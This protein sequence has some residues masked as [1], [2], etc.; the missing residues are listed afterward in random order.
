MVGCT[1]QYQICNPNLESNVCTPSSGQAAL[2]GLIESLYLNEAQL[3]TAYRMIY[4]IVDGTTYSSINGIG[5]D[6]LQIWNEVY[7]FIAPGVPDNQWQIEVRGWFETTLAKWQAFMVG[8]SRNEDSLG[9]HGHIGFPVSNSSLQQQWMHQCG[10]QKISNLGTYQ[11]ISVF[12][13]AFTWTVSWLL[14]IFSWSLKYCVKQKRKLTKRRD[15]EGPTARRVAWNIDGKFQQQRVAMTTVGYR[16]LMGGEDDVPFLE[17]EDKQPLPF[18]TGEQQVDGREHPD[19]IYR[20]RAYEEEMKDLDT[21]RAASPESPLTH[22]SEGAE[23]AETLRPSNLTQYDDQRATNKGSSNSSTLS[24]SISDLNRRE[25]LRSVRHSLTTPNIPRRDESV[26]VDSPMLS[27]VSPIND[28]HA[29]QQE[30]AE[31]DPAKVSLLADIG[32]PYHDSPAQ[33]QVVGESVQ[34]HHGSHVT[35]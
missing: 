9:S 12:G 24:A 19:T 14:M 27:E 20:S 11:N 7:D 18:F 25:T 6:A 1:E 30:P 28:T 21:G 8:Y 16:E 5:P 31:H 22:V 3:V 17:E 35:A 23:Q 33:P 15:Q 4:M 29:S 10:N 34:E 26:E 13:F 2:S 32:E